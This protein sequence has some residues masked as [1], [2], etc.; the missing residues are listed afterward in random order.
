[1]SAKEPVTTE[2]QEEKEPTFGERIAFNELY[3]VKGHSG[4]FVL[5]TPPNKSKMI[6]VGSFTK[7]KKVTVPVSKLIRLDQYVFNKLDGD[8]IHIKEV[9]DNLDQYTH[10]VLQKLSHETLMETMVPEYDPE[11]FKPHHA[12]LVLGWFCEIKIK[13]ES[14]EKAELKK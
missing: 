8:K 3:R 12:L 10:E 13:I 5:I 11:F 4:L 7:N 14:F 6:C 2:V 1:M 9:F